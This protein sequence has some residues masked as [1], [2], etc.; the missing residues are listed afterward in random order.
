MEAFY[1]R[2]TAG[3]G[4]NVASKGELYRVEDIALSGGV[5]TTKS[6]EILTPLP[7]SAPSPSPQSTIS[8]SKPEVEPTVIPSPR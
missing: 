6:G 3:E 1:R 2:S 4:K 8:P 5:L 7:A